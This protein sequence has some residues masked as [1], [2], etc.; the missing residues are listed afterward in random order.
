MA[1]TGHIGK[2][3]QSANP[4]Q[5]LL[6]QALGGPL[7]LCELG[8]MEET[9]MMASNDEMMMPGTEFDDVSEVHSELEQKPSPQDRI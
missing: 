5:L 7:W 9:R 1:L 2:I 4:E 6:L 8:T 3:L